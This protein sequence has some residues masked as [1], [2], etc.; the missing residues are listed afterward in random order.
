[1]LTTHK[2]T[3]SAF[4]TLDAGDLDE[5]KLY[6]E[7]F[8]SSVNAWMLHNNLQLNDDKTNFRIGLLPPPPPPGLSASS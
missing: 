8:F 5:T 6:L 2:C 3:A 7:A 1:M 4:K